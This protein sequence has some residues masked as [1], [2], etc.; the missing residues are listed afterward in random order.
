MNELILEIL[1]RKIQNGEISVEDIKVTE[2][3]T[4]IETWVAVQS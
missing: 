2:Y 1:K 3:K 4:A